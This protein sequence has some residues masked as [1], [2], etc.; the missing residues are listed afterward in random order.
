MSLYYIMCSDSAEHSRC[1]NAFAYL[2]NDCLLQP[3]LYFTRKRN[4]T[5]AARQGKS[6]YFLLRISAKAFTQSVSKENCVI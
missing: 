4:V 1:A 2:N 5:I 6:L 3:S